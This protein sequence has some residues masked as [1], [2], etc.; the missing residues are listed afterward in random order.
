[1]TKIW[2]KL[3]KNELHNFYSSPDIISVNK[4]RRMGWTEYVACMRNEKT[5]KVLIGK[6]EGKRSSSWKTQV[7]SM[8]ALKWVFEKSDKRCS[9]WIHVAQDRDQ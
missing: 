9:D 2:R 5:Y 7:H 3:H 1:V 4:S 6:L 8:I